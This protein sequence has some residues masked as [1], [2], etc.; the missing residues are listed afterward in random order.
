[1]NLFFGKGCITS[2]TNFDY[3]CHSLVYGSLQIIVK[4]TFLSVKKGPNLMTISTQIKKE[5]SGK[6]N[7]GMFNFLQEKGNCIAC[8]KSIPKKSFSFKC[9]KHHY[10]YLTL[11]FY[12][13]ITD[14][15]TTDTDVV[16]LMTD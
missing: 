2:S 8:V 11:S 5:V 7:C 6:V 16:L 15:A 10:I 3:F 1:M 4:R 13:I 14:F 9:L 12:Q